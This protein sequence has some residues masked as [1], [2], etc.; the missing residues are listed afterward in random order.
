MDFEDKPPQFDVMGHDC[1]CRVTE[2]PP[3]YAIDATSLSLL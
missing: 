2:Q 3:L 1:D